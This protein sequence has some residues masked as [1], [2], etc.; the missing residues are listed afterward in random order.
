MADFFLKLL[1]V[2]EIGVTP[3]PTFTTHCYCCVIL[4]RRQ[5]SSL[6]TWSMLTIHNDWFNISFRAVN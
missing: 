1:H 6:I 3:S 4:N 2:Y 5:L